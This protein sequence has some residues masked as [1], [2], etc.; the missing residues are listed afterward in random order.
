MDNK[1]SF[2]VTVRK[3]ETYEKI[4]GRDIISMRVLSFCVVVSCDHLISDMTDNK[5]C[6]TRLKRHKLA[7]SANYTKHV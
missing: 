3:C 5:R 7:Q 2:W 1:C 4:Y 6:K